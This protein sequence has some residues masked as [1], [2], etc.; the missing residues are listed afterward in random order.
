M[1]DFTAVRDQLKTWRNWNISPLAQQVDPPVPDSLSD[2]AADNWRPLF[3]IADYAAGEWVDRAREAARVLT[4]SRSDDA[5]I[6]T[7]LLADIRYV[8]KSKG[9]N[10]ISSADLAD[11]L[12]GLEDK[13]WGQHDRGRPIT[14]YQM[15]RHLSGY[16]I[17]PRVL[18]FDEKTVRG[19]S[20]DLFEDAFARYLPPEPVTPQQDHNFNELDEGVPA[21][22]AATL[23][24][25]T[26]KPIDGGAAPVSD[27]VA[28]PGAGNANPINDVTVLRGCGEPPAKVKG[29]A[30]FDPDEMLGRRYDLGRLAD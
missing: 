15:A 1:D 5:S 18:R 14:P 19:Y 2:R 10:R 25:T 13:Q 3:A 29:A 12:V 21:T 24:E 20:L 27:D 26:T 7:Q 28:A 22:E 4:P 8:F 16:G 9:W 11:E 30:A 6:G 17:R 23:D